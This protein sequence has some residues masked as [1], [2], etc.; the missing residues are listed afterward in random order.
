MEAAQRSVLCYRLLQGIQRASS[1]NFGDVNRENAKF[2]EATY[3]FDPAFGVSSLPVI[4]L[5]SKIACCKPCACRSS[6]T[7]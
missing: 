2:V 7:A 3:N 1:F 5:G 4:P 6:T